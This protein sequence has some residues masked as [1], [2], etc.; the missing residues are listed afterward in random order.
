[1]DAKRSRF[2]PSYKKIQADSERIGKPGE[3]PKRG[4]RRGALVLGEPVTANPEGV[5][6]LL[7]SMFA[8]KLNQPLGEFLFESR[9]F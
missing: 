6:H 8:A 1:M 4:L 9:R 5:R 2:S 3:Y 7:L